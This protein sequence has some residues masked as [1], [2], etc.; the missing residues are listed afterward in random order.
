MTQTFREERDSL[1]AIQV[2]SERLWGAQTQR[3][4]RFFSI[5]EDRMPKEMIRAYAL[6]KKAAAISNGRSGRL[7]P[8]NTE[9]IIKACDELLAGRH[10]QDFPLFVWMTGSGTQFNMNVNEVISNRCCQVAG[11]ALGSKTPVHPNDHVNMCQSTNDSFPTAMHIAAVLGVQEQLLPNLHQL[12]TSLQTKAEQ[13]ADLIKIG[14]THLQ[15]A[16]PLTLGQEIT[17][18]ADIL[19]DNINRLE[20]SLQGVMRLCIGG[21]A[22]GTGINADQ[23]FAEAVTAEIKAMTGL[24]FCSAPNKF[25]LQGAHDDL[26]WLSAGLANLAGSLLKMANDIRLLACGP[27][28]GFNELK[29]PSNE[30]GSS[31]MPGKVNPTQCEALAM[32]AMQVIANDHAVQMGNAGGHLQMNASKPLM[33]FNIM[34]SVRIL[35]DG[36][37]NFRQFLV[38]GMEANREQINTY[39]ERSLMLVTALSPV[40]G[41]EKASAIAHHAH[42]H[43]L[44]LKQAALD[45]NLVSEEDFDRIVD[46]RRMIHPQGSDQGP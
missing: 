45:L 44:T 14:R 43:D 11:T 3:S 15:D 9:L 28:A 31:I 29:L 5:G 36:C 2:P 46:P 8:T 17:A 30:P 20:S 25:S 41:Y 32:I 37:N 6:V 21:T 23:G 35:A 22:V 42:A 12:T 1:G 18:H 27:R 7:D 10:E 13:W 26:A 39:V 4:L 24:P 19:Q 40:I 38:E 34:K 33:I 16:T